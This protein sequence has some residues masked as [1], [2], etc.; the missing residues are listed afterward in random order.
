[1]P[2]RVVWIRNDNNNSIG[3]S[4]HSL[5]WASKGA[6]NET[7]HRVAFENRHNSSLPQEIIIFNKL[8]CDRVMKGNGCMVVVAVGE[9][10]MREED[11]ADTVKRIGSKEKKKIS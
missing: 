6:I 7:I 8:V 2:C 11:A 1:M 5:R 4:G 10:I 9:G 3:G